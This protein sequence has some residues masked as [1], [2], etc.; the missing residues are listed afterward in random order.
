MSAFASFIASVNLREHS[1]INVNTERI[2]N[3]SEIWRVPIGCN[4]HSMFEP[5][6]EVA[7]ERH[8]GIQATSTYPP[9]G[10]QLCMSADSEPRPCVA[11]TTGRVFG[12]GDVLLL[13]VDESPY[14]VKLQAFTRQVAQHAVLVGAARFPGVDQQPGDRVLAD[15]GYALR[16]CHE[17]TLSEQV[18]DG[19][20]CL[21]R[22]SVHK[23]T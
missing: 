23:D 3:G 16:G 1:K 22:D 17:V 14:L 21:V 8:S 6:C 11:G 20:P 4:L 19:C 15:A 5:A 9:R 18:D 7:H 13:G 2:F 10:D 12:D